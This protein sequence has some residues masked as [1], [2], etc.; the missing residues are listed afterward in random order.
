MD[1]TALRHIP[2][3]KGSLYLAHKRYMI[4]PIEENLTTFMDCLVP[5]VHWV[6][7]D[8][9]GWLRNQERD[10][11]LSDVL[12]RVY[13]KMDYFSGRNRQVFSSLMW[14]TVRRMIIDYLRANPD[15]HMGTELARHDPK[16]YRLVAPAPVPKQVDA[17]LII[18]ELPDQV[19]SFVLARD[20]FGFGARAIR[21]VVHLLIQDEKVPDSMLIHW[22]GIQ[23]PKMCKSFVSLCI[24]WFLYEYKQKFMDLMD[25]RSNE[26][27]DEI[28]RT[29]IVER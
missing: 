17:K 26:M 2:H 21:A 8:G 24:R 3:S 15:I 25:V 7:D 4:D 28:G 12:W 10:G 20:R 9:F 16:M 18:E 14:I 11:I 6:I 5:L 23:N 29:V 19:S 13:G 1:W 22:Y 27:V